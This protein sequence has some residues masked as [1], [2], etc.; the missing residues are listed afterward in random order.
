MKKL[1]VG[2]VMLFTL[3]A[4]AQVSKGVLKHFEKFESKFVSARNVDVWLPEGYSP[5]KRYAVLYM[6]D[7]QMLF[8]STSNWNKQEWCVDETMSKLQTE[9][10]IQDCIVVAVWNSGAGRHADYF[11]QR[12][13]ENL[14]A[15]QKDNV[16]KQWQQGSRT[17]DDLKP[18]SDNYLKFL[19]T[20]LK[21]FIDKTFATHTDKDHTFVMGSSMGGLISMY[22]ICEY[23]DVFGGAACL[24][25]HW[26]GTFSP[27]NNPIPDAFVAYLKDHLPN[28]QT[29]KLY[30]DYGTKNLDSAY[31]P[32]QK[33]ADEIIKSKGFNEQNWQTLAFKGADHDERSWRARL[34][35]PLE[36]LLK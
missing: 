27:F 36:F 11:P 14:S 6:H 3:V 12:P 33:K 20:E 15:E 18:V 7:G 16:I 9:H 35:I 31:A 26:L 17:K 2:L 8:D 34:H 29:H 28:P 25:T 4:Q 1:F 21:P 22:A 32:F 19:A 23:P 24:S 30:F 5:Q 10:K 13:F